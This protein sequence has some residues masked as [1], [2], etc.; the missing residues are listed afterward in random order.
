MKRTDLVATLTELPTKDG[1]ALRALGPDVAYLEVRADLVGDLDPDWLR[2][3]FSGGLIYTLRSRAEGGAFEGGQAARQAR[4]AA[5]A[6]GYDLVDLE[7]SRDCQPALLAEIP[8]IKRLI[9]WHGSSAHLPALQERFADLARHDARFYKMIPSAVQPGDALAILTLVHSL[10]R[11]DVVGFAGG[12]MGAWTRPLAPH[13][14]SALAYGAMGAIPGAPGQLSVER[15]RDDYGF[16]ELTPVERLYG[17]V[18][19]PVMHSL[20]PR[21][22]NGAYRALGIPALYLPFESASFADF[23]LEIVE[24]MALEALDLPLTGLSVTAPFKEVALA[25]SGASSPRAQ[26]IGAANTMVLHDGVWEAET[27]D[28]EGVTETLRRG[29]VVTEGARAAVVGCGGAGKAAAYGLELAGAHVTLVNRSVKR[30]EIAA[31]ELGMPFTLLRDFDPRGFDLVVHA[32]ALGHRPD[33]PPAFDVE[34]MPADGVIVDLVYDRETTSLVRMARKAGRTAFEGRAPL[35]YQALGQFRAFT[36]REL[37][38]TLARDLLGLDKAPA[39]M[40]QEQTS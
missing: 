18:G 13:V 32:T 30:G 2:G 23:W 7:S 20:S 1:A 17:I 40:S 34:A 9:S 25:V 37:D 6:A 16:P 24:T 10:G 19:N 4:I 12:V 11:N 39:A 33:D 22:H 3:R 5:Q 26:H 36:G 38:E 21:L 15:L 28:P 35:L 31:A 27:T 8:S 29:G 14:G